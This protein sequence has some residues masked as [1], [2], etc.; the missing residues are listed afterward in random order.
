MQTNFKNRI[1]LF[2]GGGALGAYQAGAY[3]GM[4]ELGIEPD[5]IV[6]ISI[7]AIN[8]ALIAGNPKEKRVERL[9]EFWDRV[10]S[11]SP[12]PL[13][14][15]LDALQPVAK[16]MSA[17][18]VA[19]FGIPGFFVPRIP[20]TEFL[21][22]NTVDA[23]SFYDT[24]P[25][26]KTLADLVDFDRINRREMRLSL[27]AVNV[28]TGSSVYFDNHRARIGP[29][30]VLASGALPPGFPSV[31]IDGEHYWDGGVVTNSPLWYV[32]DAAAPLSNAFVVQ[33]DN[34]PSRGELPRTLDQILERA[35][36]IQYSSKT[37]FNADRILELGSVFASMA[38]VL[39][40]LP[41]NLR[42]DPD[43]KKLTPF[44]STRNVSLAHLINRHSADIASSK[45]C[46][47]SR[48][49]V[50]AAWAAGREDVLDSLS[51]IDTLEPL[52]I[53]LGIRVY[54]LTRSLE[55]EVA[56]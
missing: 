14:T 34:F 47:F 20:P 15:W 45:D 9:R 30:H 49:T 25:L 10:S 41:P 6:G 40:K 43:V 36:D 24:A 54:D 23:I 19:T 50:N 2:Q 3:E 18:M 39:E 12:M 16:R 13:P 52:D 7:G 42:S 53:G 37:R 46:D 55:G 56:S 11:D 17:G 22:G 1:L 29:D 44:C 33:V 32:A 4:V 35:K 21:P 26:L 28:R 8:S 5:W 38:R 27:G 51:H 31:E 48:A